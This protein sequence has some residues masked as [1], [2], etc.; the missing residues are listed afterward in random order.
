MNRIFNLFKGASIATAILLSASVGASAVPSFGSNVK[1]IRNDSGG[2]LID[3]VL[4]VKKLERASG[5]VRFAGRC[6]SACTMFL[7]MNGSR[8]CIMPGASFGFHLPYGVSARSNQIAASY[9]MKSYPG[10]VRNWIYSNG[11]LSSGIKR[12]NFAYASRFIRA[13]ETTRPTEKFAMS[14]GGSFSMRTPPGFA[15]PGR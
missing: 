14:F 11:G 10:W 7:T 3:Y 13:C 6:D 5:K 2:Y 9:M 12:M 4:R 15:I 8:A 1:T